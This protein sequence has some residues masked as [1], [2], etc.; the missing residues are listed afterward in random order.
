MST[1]TIHGIAI[2]VENSG[3]TTDK[4]INHWKNHSSESFKRVLEDLE[5][6]QNI[7]S[8]GKRQIY[9]GE[10]ENLKLQWDGKNYILKKR[11]S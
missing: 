6:S 2:E 8:S 7:S 9:V 3:S 11:S 4:L 10:E 1:E 5:D